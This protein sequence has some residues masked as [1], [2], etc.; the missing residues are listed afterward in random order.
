[1]ASKR[2]YAY[3]LKGN[4]IAIIQ[5]E[6]ALAG[7]SNDEYGMYKS[8]TEDI[9][10]GLEIQYSYSPIYSRIFG[11]DQEGSFRHWKCLGYTGHNGNGSCPA[12]KHMMPNGTCMEG[13]Y[14]GAVAGQNGG[15]RRKS[16][17]RRAPRRRR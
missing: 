16:A 7:S 6:D 11:E 2:K 8:P 4:K 9:T 3:Y 15:Y 14:H 12:G 17:R 10:D 13:A 5:R 1:M